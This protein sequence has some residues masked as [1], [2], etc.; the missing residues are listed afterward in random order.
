MIYDV[1]RGRYRTFLSDGLAPF[2]FFRCSMEG[3]SQSLISVRKLYKGRPCVKTFLVEDTSMPWY[4]NSIPKATHWQC[5]SAVEKKHLFIVASKT[6]YKRIQGVQMHAISSI[7]YYPQIKAYESAHLDDF[8]VVLS[9]MKKVKGSVEKIQSMALCNQ[10]TVISDIAS[11]IA[12]CFAP[13]IRKACENKNIATD[14]SEFRADDDVCIICTD[15]VRRWQWSGCYHQTDGPSLICDTCK[16][17]I[18]KSERMRLLVEPDSF[19]LTKCI[20]C[21]QVSRLQRSR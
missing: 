1:Q 19:V 12:P 9:K 4:L 20:I 3:T 11:R 10:A 6:M 18:L 13:A 2:S 7:L 8:D 16:S 5:R 17:C 21:N 14:F 15:D